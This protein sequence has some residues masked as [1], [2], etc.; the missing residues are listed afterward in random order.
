MNIVKYDDSYYH[1]WNEFLNHAKNYHFFFHRDYLSYHKNRFEDHS[2]LVF[3]DKKKAIALL[4]ANICDLT[5]YSHSGLTFGGFIVKES[6]KTKTMTHIFENLK[7]YLKSIG[8]NRVYYKALPYIHHIKPSNEDLYAL[9][10][11]NA[12]PVKRDAAAVI[13]L[14]EK[15]KYSNGR[16]WS[17]NRAKKQNFLIQRS[18]DFKTFWN[19]LEHTLKLRYD[20]KPTHSLKEIEYLASKFPQNIKLYTLTKNETLL[21]GAIIYENPSV[22]HLQYVVNSIEGRELNALDLLIDRLIEIAKKDKRYFCF[23]T[24]ARKETDKPNYNLLDQKERFGA[25]C[26]IYDHYE[27]KIS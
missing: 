19:L 3:D 23:G 8:I 20:S 11:Q 12:V 21:C 1:I 13:D 27:W 17:V 4:A 14:R 15:I 26:V 5:L 9:F 2:L 18:F 22:S 24:S 25:S 6:V 16:R 7:I 10:L